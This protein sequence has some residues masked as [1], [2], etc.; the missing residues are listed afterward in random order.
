MSAGSAPRFTGGGFTIDQI[1]GIIGACQCATMMP[2]PSAQSSREV[3]FAPINGH[4][5][6]GGARQK[7]ARAGLIHRSKQYRYSTT[8]SAL[9]S[10]VCGTESPRAFAAFKFMTSW[11]FVGA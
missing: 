3:R 10:S 8:S 9:A 2:L 5:Q 7:S 4:L 1:G 11:Y 6:F